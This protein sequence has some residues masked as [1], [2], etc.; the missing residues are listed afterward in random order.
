MQRKILIISGTRAEY[1]LLKN[2]IKGVHQH[3]DLELSLLVTGSHLSE[4]YGMTVT[5]IEEDGFPIAFKLPILNNGGNTSTMI[6]AMSRMLTGLDKILISYRPDIIVLLGDRYEIF[7]AASVALI[8]NIPIA[9]IHGGELTLGA[10]DDALRHSISKMAWWHFTT[11]ETYKNRVIHLGEDPSRVFNTGAPAVD[12]VECA[13]ATQEE[14]EMFL[15]FELKRPVILATFHPETLSKENVELQLKEIWEGIKEFGPGTVIFTKANADA[16]GILVN[17]MLP[18]LFMESD[19]PSGGV[20]ASLGHRRYL[21]LMKISDVVIGNSSSLVI[22]APMVGTPS[23]NIGDRQ[24][25]R[26]RAVSVLDIPFKKRLISEALKR[27]TEASFIEA[28]KL[29]GHPFGRPGVS[30]RIVEK[31]ATL[32][33]PDR[34][35]KAFYE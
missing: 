6:E 35:V 16:G 13:D 27:V 25:G 20:V 22:E 1:G 33:L 12:N 19:A 3:P 18:R 30:S 10:V 28:T 31:L 2:I 29:S 21:S 15:G 32:P 9:H 4:Q 14:L 23:V 7:A 17:N 26:V 24:Q 8:H 11:T 5:E 34:L